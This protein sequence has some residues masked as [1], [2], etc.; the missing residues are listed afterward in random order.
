MRGPG[1]SQ[2]LKGFE[3]SEFR[4]AVHSFLKEKCEAEMDDDEGLS[5]R[6]GLQIIR[7]FITKKRDDLD[8][9]PAFSTT[10]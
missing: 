5:I 1:K 9:V 2:L 10:V 8:V 7:Q 6:V 4:K 3:S